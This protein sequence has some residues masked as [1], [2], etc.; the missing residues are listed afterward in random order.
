MRFSEQDRREIIS[1]LNKIKDPRERDRMIWML[2]GQEESMPQSARPDMPPSRPVSGRRKPERPVPT[3]EPDLRNIPKTSADPKRMFGLVVPAFFVIFAMVQ[4]GR[5]ILNFLAT[6]EIETEIPR[7]ITGGIF[8]IIGLVGV[9]R[10]LQP[11]RM[12]ADQA[13]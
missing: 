10:A 9:L 5:A 8:L 11:P 2:A 6:Q 4:I 1:K 3:D 13:S 12:K 7:L